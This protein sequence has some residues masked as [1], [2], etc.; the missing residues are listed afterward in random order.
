MPQPSSPTSD[1]TPSLNIPPSALQP[2]EMLAL[3]RTIGN[4]AVARY[5]ASGQPLRCA[6]ATS[7]P[8]TRAIGPGI[9]Q[10]FFDEEIATGALNKAATSATK[11]DAGATDGAY[12]IKMGVEDPLVVKATNKQ[13]PLFAAQL[14]KSLGVNTPDIASVASKSI[15]DKLGP[16]N[17]NLARELSKSERATV[18]KFIKGKSLDEVSSNEISDAT[19]EQFGNIAAF[20][21]LLG[22]TDLFENYDPL[23][24]M[25]DEYGNKNN[26]KNI[27]I[28]E[29][30]N[31]IDIDLDKGRSGAERMGLRFGTPTEV[32]AE[33]IANPTTLAPYVLRNIGGMLEEGP[34]LRVAKDNSEGELRG[35]LIQRGMLRTVLRTRDNRALGQVLAERPTGKSFD[36]VEQ[37]AGAYQKLG[38]K[39]CEVAI[40]QINERIEVLKHSV[41]EQQHRVQ[42]AKQREREAQ[43]KPRVA[44]K[45]TKGGKSNKKKS[46]EAGCCF[47]TTACVEYKGLS[48]DC[49]E[50]TVLRS[51]RD[52]YLL[53]LPE[54]AALVARYYALAPTIVHRIR[55][56]EEAA[57]VLEDMYQVVRQ[58]VQWIQVGAPERAFQVYCQ[59]M[60]RLQERYLEG[61]AAA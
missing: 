41:A 38:G 42:E 60:L 6:P 56:D 26:F 59:Q 11:F 19:L 8:T 25:D 3:Q 14:A 39:E 23:G 52:T 47:L 10:R 5:V 49:E 58:C 21:M 45:N 27:I 16:L 54:G 30:G 51:F 32:L 40:E 50:L 37:T 4:Q 57:L 13:M 33:I 24:G 53:H 2:S 12:K 29:A 7:A 55:E 36:D 28:D 18:Q 20:D 34:R 48:D 1:Q 17:G 9:V 35:L 44:T 31:A 61:G 15:L 43:I 22:K 46:N